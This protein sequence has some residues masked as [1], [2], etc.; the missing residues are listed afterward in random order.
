MPYFQENILEI[1][2]TLVLQSALN[3]VDTTL[4][5][6]SKDS[7][8]AISLGVDPIFIMNERKTREVIEYK[9]KQI[10][11]QKR[12]LQKIKPKVDTSCIICPKGEPFSFQEII[13]NLDSRTS[14]L[15]ED[16]F[17]LY[18]NSYKQNPAID[19]QEIFIESKQENN[20]QFIIV[21]K[22]IN[23]QPT[24]TEN[25]FFIVILILFILISSLRVFSFKYLNN[26]FQGA[27]SFYSA[28]KIHREGS[29]IG[30]RVH[31]VL[32][33]NMFVI[34]TLLAVYVIERLDF[35][36]P[37]SSQKW[38][39]VLIIFGA[40]VVFTLLKK[41]VFFVVSTL[42]ETKMELKELVFNQNIYTRILGLVL[43]PLALILF[44]SQGTIATI[45]LYVIL[46]LALISLIMRSIRA[47]QLFISKGFSIFYFLLYLCALEITPVL[48]VVKE[49]IML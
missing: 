18:D 35:S 25:W 29:I 28:S 42:S 1:K 26:L 17:Y 39:L 38:F 13:A 9:E 11:A 40:L 36:F 37:Y 14:I 22:Q 21:E 10:V 7:L 19:N 20:N 47:F 41:V 49:V 31:F 12:K 27:I 3:Q 43:V 8:E 16:T 34:T 30:R 15:L 32:D 2:D 33:V 45:S 23:T 44:Y 6:N 46:I 48:V 4:L 24:Y 5:P